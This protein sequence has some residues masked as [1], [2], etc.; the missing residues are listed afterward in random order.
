MAAILA[1]HHGRT[2][3]GY[4][5]D[6]YGNDPY[7][8]TSP[9]LWSHCHARSRAPDFG[10]ATTGQLVHG[11][12]AVFFVTHD[13]TTQQLFCDCVFVVAE[14]VPIQSAAALY[15]PTHA[16]SHYHFDHLRNPAH[17]ESEITRFADPGLSFV[18][19]PPMPIDDWI[20]HHVDRRRQTVLEYFSTKRRKNVRVI[21]R[22]AEGLYDRIVAWTRLPGHQRLSRL[23]LSSLQPIPLDYPAAQAINWHI[24]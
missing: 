20:E 2:T 8:W 16:A 3:L 17:A 24:S 9:F 18:P 4:L 14:V 21:T 6:R 7:V 11:R 10:S 19:H 23:P 5:A 15:P 13:H 12:D 1:P 22:D